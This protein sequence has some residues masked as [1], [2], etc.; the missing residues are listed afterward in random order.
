MLKTANKKT[1]KKYQRNNIGETFISNEGYSIQV[2]DGSNRK[3]YCTINI[4][5]KYDTEIRFSSV[6]KGEIRNLLHLSVCGVG[7]IGI[8][9]YSKK[10]HNKIYQTWRDMINRAYNKNIHETYPTYTDATVCK[11]WHNFQ[12]Y[13]KWHECN[14]M[15]GYH[16][17]KDLLSCDKI[18]SSETCIFI[19]SKLNLF[20]SNKHLDNTSG[21]IGVCYHQSSNKW[22]ASISNM[23]RKTKCLGYFNSKQEASTAYQNQRAIYAK[24]W[25][26]EMQGILPTEAIQR[27]K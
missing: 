26:G 9:K 24:Q 23:D 11:D 5:G 1:I 13:A 8:G 2:V 20:L 7:F 16:L 27:I 10:S 15:D 19:P 17:D 25:Q 14:Y 4:D 12:N 3:G 22:R 21:Y 18:Y 6:K